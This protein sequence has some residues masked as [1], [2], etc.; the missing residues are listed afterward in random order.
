[1]AKNNTV[2]R[3]LD[4]DDTQRLVEHNFKIKQ[5]I[6]IHGQPGIGKSDL[7]YQVG[8]NMG[9]PVV[10]I[11]L[12]L[13][14]ETDIRGIPYYNSNENVMEWAIPVFFP[15][16]Y[17]NDN[18]IIFLDEITQA[19][20]AVQSAALQLVLNRK[21]GEYTLP[22]NA[23]IC[24][25]GNRQGD[26]TGSKALTKALANRFKHI[27]MVPQ[28]DTWRSWAMSNGIH[29]EIIGFLSKNP[30]YMNQFDP[31][32]KDVA[33]ATPRTW[34]MVSTS[35]TEGDLDDDLLMDDVAGTVGSAVAMEFMAMRK[36][37]SKVPNPEDILSGKVKTL[38][39]ETKRI[40]CQYMVMSGCLSMMDMNWKNSVNQ[41]KMDKDEWNNQVNNF[42]GFSI[43][44]LS[45]E[46][47]AT[48]I[49]IGIK[50]MGL[51]FD[52]KKIPNYSKF[53]T[54]PTTKRLFKGMHT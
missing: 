15:K 33:F 1:M 9:R 52:A 54:D 21:V 51:K 46:I 17:E 6:M 53:F 37:A 35:M 24:A 48:G 3:E 36:I 38:H 18:S 47:I 28:F 43:E 31:Q 26:K 32:S 49:R 50:K 2:E 23:V 42:F 39:E 29:P 11:R 13:M 8:K 4:F 14:T 30:Q 5:P 7:I 27:N 45:P 22:K 40:D 10:D 41:N 12:L 25:A 34:A 19:G 16:D 44:N 20:P